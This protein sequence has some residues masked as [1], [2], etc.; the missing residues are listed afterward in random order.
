MYMP[1]FLRRSALAAGFGSISIPSLKPSGII[2]LFG[3]L[4]AGMCGA[5]HASAQLQ[6]AFTQHVPDAIGRGTAKLIVHLPASQNLH[7]ILTLP[8]RNQTELEGF[9]QAVS[10]R[11]SPSY[12]QY[13]TV[14]EFT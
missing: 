2:A 8:I 10:D 3:L 4:F 14:E 6:P 1:W 12:R 5:T 13:L 7:L 11:S 9:I